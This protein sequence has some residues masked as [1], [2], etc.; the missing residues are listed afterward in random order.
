MTDATSTWALQMIASAFAG[1][2]IAQLITLIVWLVT[3]PW[4]KLEV[5]SN[6]PLLLVA[7]TC[8]ESPTGSATWIRVRVKNCG[9]RDAQS[10]RA[11]LTDITKEG[12]NISI[13]KEENI[14]ILKEDVIT[15]WASAGGDGKPLEGLTI[16]RGF[17]R[18]FDIGFVPSPISHLTHATDPDHPPQGAKKTFS[19]DHLEVA[20]P[21]FW[22]RHPDSLPPG[23]Y[24]ISIAASGN[25]FH[26]Q[27]RKIMIRFKDAST[28]EVFP[29]LLEN[30]IL[31]MED[32]PMTVQPL[33]I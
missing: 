22:I 11:Y 5:G 33:T 12:E 14:S 15:L 9:W 19:V 27:T 21:E 24:T 32:V 31:A 17:S 26:P 28:V 6:V 3:Q 25:N 16:S 1:G 29:L 7:A 30:G 4:L 8:A 23:T 20:S 13:L 2:V 18:F 10:C